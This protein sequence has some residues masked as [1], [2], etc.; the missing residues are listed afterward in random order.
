MI[1]IYDSSGTV[2]LVA[3][4]PEDAVVAA[5]PAGVLYT[6]GARIAQDDTSLPV[7]RF[8]ASVDWNDGSPVVLFSGTNTLNLSAQKTLRYGTY[9]V[10]VA[11]TGNEL[12]SASSAQVNFTVTVTP[13]A[14]EVELPRI[15]YGPVL[16]RDTGFPGPKDWNF[17]VSADL[18]VLE[19]SAKM[20]LTTAKGERVMEPDYGT[21]LRQLIFDPLLS[22][23]ES[24]VRQE[25][26]D[27]LSAW[28]PRLSLQY[29]T[30]QRDPGGRSVYIY[31]TLVSNLNRRAF[32]LAL[33]YQI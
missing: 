29:M 14:P 15:I 1:T 22:S 25:I 12:P 7:R 30:V 26:A 13:A 19:S 16:P 18:Y 8:E 32:D 28:E 17:N 9:S 4:P 11:A 24:L 6:V 21:R 31:C 33:N 3:L 10:R 2:D 23:M 27:A 20:L 5:G